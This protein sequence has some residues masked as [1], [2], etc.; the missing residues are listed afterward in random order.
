MINIPSIKKQIEKTRL[1]RVINRDFNTF[2]IPEQITPDDFTVEDLFNEYQRLQS[3]IPATGSQDSHEYLLR[4]SLQ[5]TDVPIDVKIQ[6]LLENNLEDLLEQANIEEPITTVPVEQRNPFIRITPRTIQVQGTTTSRISQIVLIQV[7]LNQGSQIQPS[8]SFTLYSLNTSSSYFGKKIGT[9]LNKIDNTL[10]LC[11]L[12]LEVEVDN[13][14]SLILS[15]IG[16]TELFKELKN[17]N[18]VTLTPA[19][20]DS[21]KYWLKKVQEG[22]SNSSFVEEFT[23][24]TYIYDLNT[25]DRVGKVY[26]LNSPY[27]IALEQVTP[28]GLQLLGKEFNIIYSTFAVSNFYKI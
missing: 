10:L 1:E 18:T 26:S 13:L 5:F 11:E 7:P 24:N 14:T 2:I 21:D 17:N 4:Q 9:L 16:T 28:T 15:T 6:I 23:N 3:I 22:T 8:Q 25:G 19:F 27:Q 20:F 12:S